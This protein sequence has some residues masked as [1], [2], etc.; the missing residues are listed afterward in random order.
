MILEWGLLYLRL[1]IE[2]RVW[3]FEV[4]DYREI[5]FIYWNYGRE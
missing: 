1:L 2:Y 4:K 3:N 5:E